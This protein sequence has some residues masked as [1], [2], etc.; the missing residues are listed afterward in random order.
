MQGFQLPECLCSVQ[1][2][3]QQGCVT[4]STRQRGLSR[5]ETQHRLG[6]LSAGRCF[7]QRQPL[8]LFAAI[9]NQSDCREMVNMSKRCLRA[10]DLNLKVILRWLYLS[11][12][13]ILDMLAMPGLLW[14]AEHH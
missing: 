11:A 7:Q 9:A 10:L 13:A 14:M 6:N 1:G 12:V 4:G 5:K 3:L 8:A 2:S